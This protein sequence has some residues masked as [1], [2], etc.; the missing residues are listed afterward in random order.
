[1]ASVGRH[2]DTPAAVK[3]CLH[4][5]EH[6]RGAWEA[7][8]HSAGPYLHCMRTQEPRD[9]GFA[10]IGREVGMGVTGPPLAPSH[11]LGRAT[12]QTLIAASWRGLDSLPASPTWRTSGS[13]PPCVETAEASRL[14]SDSH[15]RFCYSKPWPDVSLQCRWQA[16]STARPKG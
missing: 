2:Y 12:V 13:G 5:M 8:W 10:S 3:G 16:V 15:R 1:V 7:G 4:G 11:P 9:P 6:A 14:R